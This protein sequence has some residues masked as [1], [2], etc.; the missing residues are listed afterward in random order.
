MFFFTS[1]SSVVPRNCSD[2]DVRLVG[3]TTD[4]EGRVEI[5]INRVWGTICFLTDQFIYM[6]TTWDASDARVVCQQLGYLDRGKYSK[7]AWFFHLG[8]GGGGLRVHVG[9]SEHYFQN[10]RG[11]KHFSNKICIDYYVT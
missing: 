1:G 3:G 9:G 10:S 4:N 2:G 11:L 6:S 7:D 8:G 5:C